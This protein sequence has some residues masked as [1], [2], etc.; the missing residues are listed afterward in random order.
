MVMYRNK[1]VSGMDANV[2]CLFFFFLLAA[3]NIL[4][5]YHIKHEK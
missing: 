1:H 3:L 5:K 2:F 4:L